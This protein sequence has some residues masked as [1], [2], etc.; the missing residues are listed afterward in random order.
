MDG[1]LGT[2]VR[3]EIAKR[4]LYAFAK[5]WD[6]G[7][8]QI[9]SSTKPI[10]TPEDL[11]G[12]KIR[13]PVSPLWTS[14][15]QAFGASPTGINFN[16]V[17]SA[18]QTHIVDG[19]ENPLAIIDTA[20]L[21]EVQKYLA[22]TN[23]SWAGIHYSFSNPAWKRLP[24]NL[25]D[26]STKHFSAA[27]LTERE[28]WQTMTK[29][30]KEKLTGKGMVFNTPDTKPFREVLKQAGFYTDMKKKSGDKAWGLLEKYVG[31]L[32]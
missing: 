9:T 12:F 32:T 23:H 11:S 17:Y 30:E 7:Y 22:I 14:M 15:F 27:A 25:Q 19:Q 28:D 21:Y 4:G 1:A 10:R 8:R 31:P 16:E 26:L 5:Q 18:L 13:V 3:A 29:E 24:A 6:N 2:F 20:K